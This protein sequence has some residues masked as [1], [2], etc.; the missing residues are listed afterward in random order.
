M[1]DRAVIYCV[2]GDKYAKMAFKSA[3]SLRKNAEAMANIPIYVYHI[4]DSFFL[5]E[6]FDELGCRS[7]G[8]DPMKVRES[9]PVKAP[10]YWCDSWIHPVTTDLSNTQRSRLTRALIMVSPPSVRNVML[11]ADTFVQNDFTGL[12]DLMQ[13][14]GVVGVEDGNF[15]SHLGMAKR[16][17]FKKKVNDS[18]K[19]IKEHLGVD[20]SIKPPSRYAPYFNM[21]VFGFHACQNTRSLGAWWWNKMLELY[22][23][24]EH[25]PFDDQLLMNAGLTQFKI[26]TISVNPIFNYTRSRMK[27]NMKSGLHEKVKDQVRIIHN[28][29]LGECEWIKEKLEALQN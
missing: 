4:G 7:I 28:R 6:S 27:N 5:K 18:A 12:F 29:R 20:Y 15:D 13:K 17:F 23:V 16:L 24:P 19:F 14:G 9:I 1:E 26:P 8:I 21:G 10:C 11:D 2:L 22:E 25:D 3:S